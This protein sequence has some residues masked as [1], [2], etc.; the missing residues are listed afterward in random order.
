MAQHN[1]LGK[2]AEEEVAE[3][4]SRLGY[5]IIDRNWNTKWCEID[6]VA[7]KS[8]CIYF[9]EV[10]YRA[11]DTA[12]SG[13]EYITTKKLQQMKRAAE[14]WVLLNDWEGEYVLSAAEVT[15]PELNI[16]FVDEI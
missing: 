11:S 2:E 13:L 9:V 14:S 7:K 12:G 10:K 4:L 3:Y 15:G 16:E 1:V 6:I 5:K 8:D